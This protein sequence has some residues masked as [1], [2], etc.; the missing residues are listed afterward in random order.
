MASPLD[1]IIALD[2]V[3]GKLTVSASENSHDTKNYKLQVGVQ[4]HDLRV[5]LASPDTGTHDFTMTYEPDCNLEEITNTLA[6]KVGELEI[7]VNGQTKT[8][9]DATNFIGNQFDVKQF[10][11]R[12][13][14]K[15]PI[16]YTIEANE[17]SKSNHY[18]LFNATTIVATNG[19]N[20][21]GFITIPFNKVTNKQV[22][23]TGFE[24]IAFL[25][26]ANKIT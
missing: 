16:K 14:E 2:P 3:T 24:I 15:C 9:Y 5:T 4:V 19:N 11:S 26:G 13:Y 1:K 7:Y 6:D 18:D 20:A 8:D 25:D 23:E 12:F 10:K 21:K 22:G 17:L